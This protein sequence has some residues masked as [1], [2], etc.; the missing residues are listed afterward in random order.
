MYSEYFHSFSKAKN[1]S[2]K[3]EKTVIAPYKPKL[4]FPTLKLQESKLPLFL[5]F[6][7]IFVRLAIFWALSLKSQKMAISQK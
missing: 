2:L 4:L 7:L 1:T 5:S 3:E 6:L